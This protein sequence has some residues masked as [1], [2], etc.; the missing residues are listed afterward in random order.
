[1]IK[2]IDKVMAALGNIRAMDKLHVDTFTENLIE[3]VPGDLIAESDEGQF[4]VGVQ[5]LNGYYFLETTVLSA[6][7]VKTYKGAHLNFTGGKSDFSLKSDTQEIKSEYSN[8]SRRYMS[9]IS[10]EITEQ[11]IQRIQEGDFEQIQFM[12]KKKVLTFSKA[13]DTGFEF[14][15]PS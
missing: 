8:V 6:I 5:E 15:E 9:D 3:N 2:K 12:F 7:G 4:F 13:S 11:E 10:F 14:H 1:M